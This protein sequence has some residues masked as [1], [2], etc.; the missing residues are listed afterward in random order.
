MKI[1]TR[2]AKREESMKTSRKDEGVE[3]CAMAWGRRDRRGVEEG[4]FVGFG[5]ASAV[6]DD[7]DAPCWV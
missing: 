2:G 7:D 6:L 4:V 1:I 3:Y 5:D